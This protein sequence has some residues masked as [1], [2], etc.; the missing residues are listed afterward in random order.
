MEGRGKSE[1]SEETK[2]SVRKGMKKEERGSSSS[3]KRRDR[4]VRGE[5]QEGGR[6][7]GRERLGWRKGGRS[8]E[9]QQSYNDILLV[10]SVR[11][12]LL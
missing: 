9:R 7:E 3:S 1:E 10:S 4:G 5:R 6:S 8:L 2:V 11:M 12:L